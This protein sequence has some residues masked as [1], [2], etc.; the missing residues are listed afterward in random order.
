[1]FYPFDR[2]DPRE[3]ALLMA[4]AAYLGQPDEID[5]VFFMATEGAARVLG[6][7]DYGTGPGC[8][9]D[10]AIL[11]ARSPVQAIARQADRLH[12][13]RRGRVVARTARTQ[14]VAAP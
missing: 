7:T 5:T 2:A 3:I 14:T 6:A 9:G 10:L 11:D 12:V 4:H 8:V 13:I 1:M